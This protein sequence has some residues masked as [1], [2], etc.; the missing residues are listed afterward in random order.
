MLRKFFRKPFILSL[1]RLKKSFTS[2]T[3]FS[4][5]ELK[6]ETKEEIDS[7]YEDEAYFLD[8]E[9]KNLKSEKFRL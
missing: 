1:A 5:N 8:K 6:L 2:A 9:L 3:P 7:K 4:N